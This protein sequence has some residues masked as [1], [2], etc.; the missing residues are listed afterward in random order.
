LSGASIGR[1]LEAGGIGEVGP[2]LGAW[3]RPT[4]VGTGRGSG[5]DLASGLG[6]GAASGVASAA[7]TGLTDAPDVAEASLIMSSMDILPVS[8]GFGA[9]SEGSTTAGAGLG[10]SATGGGA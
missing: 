10:A 2:A 5:S 4:M 8:A 6:S 7:S 9:G 1:I 3:T